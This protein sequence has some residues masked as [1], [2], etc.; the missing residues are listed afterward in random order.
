MRRRELIAGAI[1]LG[2]VGVGA[3][4]TT[5]AETGTVE[6]I[7]VETI[8]APGS[9]AGTMTVPKR[10]T[11]S[12]VEFF[13]TW[14]TTCS[15]MM[16]EVRAAHDEVGDEAD[17]VSVTYEPLGHS[18]TRDDVAEWWQDH[19]GAWT[20]AHDAEFELTE[21][22]GVAGVPT[23]AVLDAENRVVLNDGGYKT[24]DEFVEAVERAQA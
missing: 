9:E 23:T 2:T 8:E 5:R 3:Y 7:E 12:L 18:V 24:E 21:A 16:P 14:C 19:D 22:L 1:G 6:P 15:S 17:F 4:L 20:V 13:A 10:G 11:V